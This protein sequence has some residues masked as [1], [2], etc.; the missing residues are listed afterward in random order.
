MNF[1]SLVF[2]FTIPIGIIFLLAITGLAF[3]IPVQIEENTIASTRQNAEQVVTQYKTLR[4]YYV[5]NVV[6][7]VLGASDI[8]PAINH[9]GNPKAIPLPAT[10]I[11]DLSKAS[12]GSGMKIKLY[13]ALPFPNRK[14]RKL[15][16]FQKEAWQFLQNNNKPY[17]KKVVV[18]GETH[19]R[20]A[21]ADKMVADACVNC[22]NN[23]PDT[24]KNNWKLGDVRGVL[25][26]DTNIE[27]QLI[28]GATTSR[29]I[30]VLLLGILVFS[31]LVIYLVFK[32]RIEKKILSINEAYKHVG[33]GDLLFRLDD[34]S[35]DELGQSATLFNQ[36]VNK[37]QH[38]LIDIHEGAN[39][40]S[41]ASGEIS[42]TAGSL[43][44]MASE[45]A[46]SVE[47]TSASLEQM[48]ASIR[49]NTENS[50]ATDNIATSTSKQAV[51]GGAA[52][53]ETAEAMQG[54]AS[55]ISLIEDIAYKTNLL[56][57]NAAIEAARA[58]EHG[59]GFAVVA[60]EVRKLA[61]RSQNSAQE[62]AELAGNSVTISQRAG[63]LIEDM[64][65]NIQKTADLVQEIS[66]GSTEQLSGV[67]QIN[68]AIEQVDQSA[69]H[70]ASS[71]EELAA[72]A[73]QMNKQV[74]ELR[75]TIEFFKL[76][77]E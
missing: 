23:H 34:D 38:V 72:T 14:N 64:L 26:I 5:K 70:G 28:M 44:K 67:G 33:E 43:S 32:Y 63:E 22:H 66:A 24:P 8:K 12:E 39:N 57:L 42:Q 37:I 16:A 46:A 30:I 69:Q 7:K 55:K 75:K 76:T 65:P 45:Q 35:L 6:K 2:K 17:V 25:E 20:V 58:G 3:Y 61:E 1:N 74:D 27:S 31:L 36:F 50:Q 19:I 11:H 48:G 40:I 41:A 49:Q 77:G 60:D 4:S 47:E 15:D 56:A 73:T 10:L 52:V 9:S 51:E 59:K 53:K 18:N 21:L 62:I 29:G 13:S 54:I 71:S 68:S